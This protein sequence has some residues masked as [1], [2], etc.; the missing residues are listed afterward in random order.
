M[1]KRLCIALI[2]LVVV[3]ALISFVA[4]AF[5]VCS[6]D[7]CIYPPGELTAAIES[8]GIADQERPKR[9]L[10]GTPDAERRLRE[11][12]IF[13]KLIEMQSELRNPKTPDSRKAQLE[14]L[15]ASY[16]QWMED[17]TFP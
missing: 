15:I 13:G 3:P 10:C 12:K 11:S 14:R 1:K 17:R 7:G 8:M 6:I 9:P 16:G 4:L 5:W 2:A